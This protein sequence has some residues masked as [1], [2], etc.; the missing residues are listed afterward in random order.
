MSS[1]RN[2]ILAMNLTPWRR[3]RARKR[4]MVRSEM[5]RRSAAISLVRRRLDIGNPW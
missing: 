1:K 3:P 5:F 4:S 2:R